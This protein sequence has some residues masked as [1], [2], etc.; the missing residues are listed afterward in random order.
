[1]G[2]VG[3]GGVGW[4]EMT[5]LIVLLVSRYAINSVKPRYGG[6][7]WMGWGEAWWLDWGGVLVLSCDLMVMFVIRS[8]QS[9][10][11]LG[12]G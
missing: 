10:L 9:L 7:A 6:W 1:M 5:M 12:D 2:W 4:G 8:I 11:S 3:W